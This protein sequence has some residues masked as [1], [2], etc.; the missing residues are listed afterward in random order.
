M[1]G[2]GAPFALALDRPRLVELAAGSA[3][4]AASSLVPP[5]LQPPGF[6][7]DLAANGA[8]ARRLLDE[9]GY[10]DRSKLGTIVVN[11]T[12]LDAAPAV[13]TWGQ[14]LR[15]QDDDRDDELR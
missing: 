4:Q 13:A 7:H 6:P 5:A 3:Q 12:G 1:L 2:C 14:V 9:A 15:G 8:E 10:A 11:G